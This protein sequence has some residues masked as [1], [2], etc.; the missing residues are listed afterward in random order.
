VDWKKLTSKEI[1][2]STIKEL[3]KREITAF[4]VQNGQDAKEKA[5]SLVPKGSQV[6]VSTSV[7]SEQIG[8]KDTID[9]GR[10]YKSVRNEYMAL[11][12]DTEAD[13]IRKLR[14]APEVIIGSVHAVTENGEVLVA[15]NTG[16]QIPGYSYA[17]GKVIWLV[18]TQKIVKN[19]EEAF[20]RLNEY[21]VPLEE[22]HMQEQYG[23]G[24][25]LSKI[26]IINKEK[27]K[28][29]IFLIFI[30]EVLGF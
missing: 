12:K 22:Q 2:E 7:T 27:V 15:S 18:G 21:V 8:L 28:N 17:A 14:S 19:M 9:N 24:T 6:L 11:D 23:V 10:D 4:Y 13:K 16:S 26:L 25:N 5:L 3:E 20:K 30:N 1:V 29:R